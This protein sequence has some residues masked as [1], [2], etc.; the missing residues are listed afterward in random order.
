MADVCLLAV[1]IS[2]IIGY[3]FTYRTVSKYW[4]DVK[5]EHKFNVYDDLGDRVPP[6]R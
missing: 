6:I 2:S 3:S 4:E 1:A 5:H